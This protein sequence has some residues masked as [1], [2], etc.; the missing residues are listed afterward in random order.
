MNRAGDALSSNPT[1]NVDASF[2]KTSRTDLEELGE[3]FL[4]RETVKFHNFV[5]RFVAA[6]QFHP[7]SGT[8]QTSGQQFN[9]S[10][11]G[12]RIH[13]RRGNLDSQFRPQ[14]PADFIG[15]RAGQ[16]FYR[17]QRAI[18]L[19]VKKTGNRHDLYVSATANLLAGGIKGAAGYNECH[20]S[21][22]RWEK[23]ADEFQ[24]IF[25]HKQ[26]NYS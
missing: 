12:R 23:R 24:K 16:Q 21:R 11:I 8:I 9:Q 18:R 6:N 13:G 20:A 1:K 15:G 3:N 19:R 14:R 17:K 2:G 7:A 5:P 4:R 26:K 25:V 10:F 22:G